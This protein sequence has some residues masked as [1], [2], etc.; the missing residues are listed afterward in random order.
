M[1]NGGIKLER[2]DRPP[3]YDLEALESADLPEEM[4]RNIRLII[5]KETLA[6]AKESTGDKHE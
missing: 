4:K 2:D 5:S 6:K 3:K 1:S